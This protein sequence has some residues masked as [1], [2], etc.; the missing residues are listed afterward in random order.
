MK[1]GLHGHPHTN[2]Y[3]NVCMSTYTDTYTHTHTHMNKSKNK[4]ES[5][6]MT[7]VGKDDSR[8]KV[9]GKLLIQAVNVKI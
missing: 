4:E 1:N 3:T 8:D 5:I 6:Q 9:I 7:S 2:I